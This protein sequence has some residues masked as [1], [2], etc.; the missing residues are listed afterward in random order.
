MTPFTEVQCE[1]TLSNLTANL[2][3]RGILD[4]EI[5]VMATLN[6]MKYDMFAFRR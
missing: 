6:K 4:D 2:L 1:T 5:N 3:L